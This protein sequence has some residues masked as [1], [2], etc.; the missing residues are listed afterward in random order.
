M[1][2]PLH[3]HIKK[4]TKEILLTWKKKEWVKTQEILHIFS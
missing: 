2:L 1:Q 4:K 3:R